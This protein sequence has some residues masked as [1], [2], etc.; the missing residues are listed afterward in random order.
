MSQELVEAWVLHESSGMV[1]SPFPRKLEGMS[2]DEK[3]V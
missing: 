3:V 1:M 2:H